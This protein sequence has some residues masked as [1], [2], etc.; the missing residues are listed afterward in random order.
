M[1]LLA[2]IVA[3]GMAAR[4]VD[5]SRQIRTGAASQLA[6]T[7]APPPTVHLSEYKI[8]P[9]VIKAAPGDTLTVVNDG[10]MQHNL[11]IDGQ[12]LATP[13]INPGDSASMALNG[14]AAGTYTV[15]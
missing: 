10:S 2:S 13:M 11:A 14:L 12:S 9:T 15:L 8:T 5:Q 6:A 7:A 3:W 4:A 1:C